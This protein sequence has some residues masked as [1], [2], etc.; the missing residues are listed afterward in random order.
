MNQP[1]LLSIEQTPTPDSTLT[2]KDV[3]NGEKESEYFTKL[4]KVIANER[5]RGK[6]IYPANSEIFNAL[7]LTPFNLAKV[8]IIGQDPYHGPNQAHGL[9]F[10]VRQGVPAPPSLIN[11]FKELSEDLGVKVPAHGSLTKWA[12]Q[13]VLLLNAVLTVENGNPQSHAGLGWERFTDRIIRELNDRKSGLVFLLWGSHAQKKCEQIDPKRH[14]VLKAPHPSPL[15]A[16]RGFFGC[17]HFSRANQ[18]LKNQ[19]LEPINW[20]LSLG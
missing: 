3:L 14:F 19:G 12:E 11:I 10:S 4:L 17:K 7:A 13:G 6:L 8:V 18:I 5:A 1:S 2:W 20:D 9:C 15:S 16:H